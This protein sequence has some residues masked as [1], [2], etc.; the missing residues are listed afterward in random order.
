MRIYQHHVYS[1]IL[2]HEQYDFRIN[3][4]TVKATHKVLNTILNAINNRK[5]VGCIFC[6]LHKAFDCV[7]HKILLAKLEFY[8]ITG[9]FLNVIEFYNEDRYQTVSIHSNNISSNWKKITHGVPQGLILG[10][11][12]SLFTLMICIKY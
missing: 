7:N 4:S 11:Y 1:N 8:G 2:I 6:D 5:I 10:P 9:K 3:S 12:C